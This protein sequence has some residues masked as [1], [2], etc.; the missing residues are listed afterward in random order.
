MYQKDYILRM[1][2]EIGR[3]LA[4]LKSKKNDEKGFNEFLEFIFTHFGIEP[5][6]L[7]IENISLLEEKLKNGMDEYP[8]ELGQLLFNGGE[9][10]SEAGRRDVTEVMYLLAWTSFMKAEKESG[11]Y[12]FERVVEMNEI[13]D[14]LSLMGINVE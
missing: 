5:E 8:D 4:G 10:A 3:F 1:I 7:H 13:K 14:K 2:E 9:T 6:D 12:R 11:T